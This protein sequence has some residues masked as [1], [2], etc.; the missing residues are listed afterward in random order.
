MATSQ[1]GGLPKDR[2]SVQIVDEAN[3]T[4]RR[5]VRPVRPAPES[6]RDLAAQERQRQAEWISRRWLVRAAHLM[7]TRVR[8]PDGGARSVGETLRDEANQ[9]AS[10]EAD[11]LSGSRKHH[12][13]PRWIRSVPKLVLFF[14]FCLLSYFFAGVT[15]V[16]WASPLSPS[17][18]IAILLAAPLTVLAYGFFSFAGHRLRSYRGHSGAI[19]LAKVDGFTRLVIVGSMADMAVLAAL[20]YIR[21]RAEVIDSL[22]PAGSGTAF[23]V[24]TAL[25]VVSV[26]ANFLVIAIHAHDGSDDVDRLKG[27]SAAASR[28]VARAQRMQAKATSK[29]EP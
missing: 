5:P 4:M 7:R 17:L 19:W 3:G 14:D 27:L 20:M 28:Q 12:R 22:G 6:Q 8:H 13:L 23:V 9:W 24:G 11:R 26:L 18:G 29:I 16:D 21:M 10:I 2:P 1:N 25:A 15:D